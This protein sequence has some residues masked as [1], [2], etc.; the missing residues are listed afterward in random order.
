MKQYA[1]PALSQEVIWICDVREQ[2]SNVVFYPRS[3]VLFKGELELNTARDEDGYLIGF[4]FRASCDFYNRTK[5]VAW[6]PIPEIGGAWWHPGRPTVQKPYRALPGDWP[7]ARE[8]EEILIYGRMQNRPGYWISLEPATRD[9]L[10]FPGFMGGPMERYEGVLGWLKVSDLMPMRVELPPVMLQ[11]PCY[12]QVVK[13]RDAAWVRDQGWNL[14]LCVINHAPLYKSYFEPLVDKKPLKFG[15]WKIKLV[16]WT[17]GNNR[18]RIIANWCHEIIRRFAWSKE[19]M[20]VPEDERPSRSM[21]E[22]AVRASVEHVLDHYYSA[23]QDAAA[24]EAAA[25]AEKEVDKILKE[26]E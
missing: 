3:D 18:R 24:A 12:M 7:Y 17:P 4:P 22:R 8:G 9:P 10:P 5:A 6:L 23:M 25:I 15:N 13:A 14:A 21:I 26:F 16:D 19:S 2:I 11:A 1:Y 20:W